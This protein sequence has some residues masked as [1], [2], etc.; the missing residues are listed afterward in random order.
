MAIEIN[1]G[2]L[3]NSPKPLDSKYARF[4]SGVTSAYTSVADANGAILSAYRSLGLTVLVLKNGVPTEYQ[5]KLGILDSNLVEKNVAGINDYNSLTNL[6]DLSLY[7][8]KTTRINGFPLS[9]DV[10]LS[11]ADF[12][13]S[14]V[15]NTP[16][17]QKP[18]SAPQLAA[19]NGKQSTSQKGLPN[20]YAPLGANNLIPS[21][22]LPSFIDNILEFNN[23]AAFPGT[24]AAGTIYLDKSTGVQYRWSGTQ[25][26]SI[27]SGAVQTVNGFTGNVTL[28]FQSPITVTTTG[29]GPATFSGNILNIPTS[30]S[31]VPTGAAGGNLSGTYPN[32]SVKF[33]DAYGLYDARYLQSYTETEPIFNTSAA[34]GI[35]NTDISNW[36]TT[37]DWGNHATAGYEVASNKSNSTSLGTST[38]LY[39]TQNAVKVYVDTKTFSA[40]V[41]YNDNYTY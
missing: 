20:G 21:S 12:G 34:F 11:K 1:D 14:L 32:P 8:P 22:F 4:S 25:Y 27:T 31:S 18:V 3:N 10:T 24:G 5:Y 39:P 37:Y 36:N 7:V 6:P 40:T 9:T 15:D 38:T 28:S 2:F 41:V 29:S 16:D 33:T 26:T 30:G 35:Q 19:L 23:Y 13:L 17:S